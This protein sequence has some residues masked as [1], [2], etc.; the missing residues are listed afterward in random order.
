LTTFDILFGSAAVRVAVAMLSKARPRVKAIA[1][2]NM[3]LLAFRLA[4]ATFS[5]TTG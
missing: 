5:S 3:T 4:R 2:Q 1:A